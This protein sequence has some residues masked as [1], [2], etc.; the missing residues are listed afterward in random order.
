VIWER[1]GVESSVAREL[2]DGLAF[3]VNGKIDGNSRGDAPTQ[4][5]GGLLGALLRP[6]PRDRARGR[7]GTGSTAGWLAASA[8]RCSDGR[9][10]AGAGDPARGAGVRAREP[11][12]LENPRVHVSSAM[13]ERC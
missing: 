6:A 1:D 7:L 2:L 5:M 11:G 9:G 8:R 12:A 3:V 13:P 10:G 4:V